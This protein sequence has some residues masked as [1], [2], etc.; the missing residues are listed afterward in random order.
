L[1]SKPLDKDA[2]EKI[3]GKSEH[4]LAEGVN[5]FFQLP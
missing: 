5:K 1:L 4:E 3:L 2:A